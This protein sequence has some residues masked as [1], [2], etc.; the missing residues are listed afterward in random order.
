MKKSLS[1]MVFEIDGGKVHVKETAATGATWDEF[2]ALVAGKVG[3]CYAVF[4]YSLNLDGGRI[5]N[6]LVFV[7]WVPDSAPV[8]KKMMYGSSLEAFKSELS[9]P[10]KVL[11]ASSMGELDEKNVKELLLKV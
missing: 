5:L 4:D 1:Y 8:R 7:S 3:G 2:K 10:F 6:K 9:T 11:Q